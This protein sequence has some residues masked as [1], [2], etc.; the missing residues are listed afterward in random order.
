MSVDFFAI[1]KETD[2]KGR[3]DGNNNNQ[4]ESTK[5]TLKMYVPRWRQGHL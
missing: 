5:V 1:L 4:P 3:V 2:S